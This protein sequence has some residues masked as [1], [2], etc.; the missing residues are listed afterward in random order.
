VR[1]N[2]TSYADPGWYQAP[3]GTVVQVASKQDL[4]RDGI[5]MGSAARQPSPTES[6]MMNMPGINH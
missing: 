4:E 1:E 6:P 3:V 2:L 5:A